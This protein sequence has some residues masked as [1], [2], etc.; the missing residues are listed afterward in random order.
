MGKKTEAVLR[1]ILSPVYPLLYRKKEKYCHVPF[2]GDIFRISSPSWDRKASTDSCWLILGEN[3]ALLIDA[4]EPGTGLRAYAQELAGDRTL[5]LALTHGHYDHTGAINDFD[6]VY[7]NA[8][9]RYLLKGVLGLPATPFKGKC[10]DI[11]D[12]DSIEL[13]GR[14]IRCYRIPGHTPGSVCYLDENTRILF[15]GDSV[16]RRGFYTEMEKTGVSQHFDALVRFEALPFDRLA[17][18]HDP[19]LLPQSLIRRYITA[20]LEHI[21]EP[22]GSFALPGIR[23]NS[24]N[25]GHD[26]NDPDYLTI[27]YPKKSQ[28][29]IAIEMDIWEE[30]HRD[31]LS[32]T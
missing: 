31:W 32:E 14:T 25:L 21:H 20:I 26:V 15:S 30:S 16:A 11:N 7:L 10:L 27:S 8:E 19:D 2:E 23:F 4:G 6:E 12:G 29:K 18:A 28:E 5:I 13:G 17:T 1:T 22:N 9:D 3:K 24:I